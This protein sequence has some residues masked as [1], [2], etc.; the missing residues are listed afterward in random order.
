MT[1]PAIRFNQVVKRYQKRT[2]LHG[3]ELD[4]LQ[5]EFFGLVGMNGAGKTTL[6]KCLLD[7]CAFDGGSIEIL[8]RSNLLTVARQ[9]MAF[10]PERFMPPYYLTGAD[11]LKYM[12]RLQDLPIVPEHVDAMLTSLDLDSSVLSRPVRS[13]SKGM[14]QKLGLAACFLTRKALYVLDEPM[15]GLDPK[16]RV[17]LK[18][19][20]QILRETG[21]TLFFSSHALADVDELCDRMAILHEGQLRFV[22]TPDE[23][24]TA[25]AAETLE[26]A[27]MR[28]IS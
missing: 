10:L 16:A 28:C 26:Q 15:S 21:G 2:V 9:P 4:I 8:G 5:G 25:Y 24:R 18:A 23:C 3:V 20:L 19:R 11:F 17:L 6:L 7:F 13:Y 22:G 27:F 1:I 12:L 14:N